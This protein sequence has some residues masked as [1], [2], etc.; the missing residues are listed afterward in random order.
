M[1]QATGTLGPAVLAGLLDSNL[2]EITVLTRGR[3]QRNFPANVAVKVVDYTSV[4]SLEAALRGQDALVSA[5]AFEAIDVQRNLVDA[6]VN[7]GVRR[8]IPS[9]YG[10]DTQNPKLATLPI[11]LP[12]IAVREYLNTKVASNPGF[13]YT[14]IMNASFLAPGFALDFIVDVK[15]KKCNVKDGGDVL[16]SCATLETIAQ[17]VVGVLNH[18]EETANRPV[19]ISD[20]DTTQKELI[21]IAKEIDPSGEWQIVHTKTEDLEREAHESWAKGD[22]SPEVID[23]FI[24]RAFLGPGWGGLFEQKDNELLGIKGLDR[25]G[26]K[27]I[28]QTAM[29][30]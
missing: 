7:A 2:F 20:R 16:F 21:S 8:M 25:N 1:N 18:F 30:A 24:N 4:A 19:K 9:E 6:A 10:N 27:S 3:P 29:A 26:L 17:A 15:N 28:V 12:K 22:H 13:S 11:Y 14:I 5:M 23:K